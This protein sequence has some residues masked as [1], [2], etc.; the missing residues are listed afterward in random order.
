MPAQGAADFDDKLKPFQKADKAARKIIVHSL[1]RRPMELIVSSTTA[2]DMWLKLN[3]V[4]DMKSEE[5]LCAVQ[6]QFFDFKWKG[7]SR[8]FANESNSVFVASKI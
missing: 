3:S 6:K 7:N 5:N 8:Q 4:F 1:E 2:R